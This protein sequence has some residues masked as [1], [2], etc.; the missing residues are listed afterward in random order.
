MSRGLTPEEIEKR[1][2]LLRTPIDFEDLIEAGVLRQEGSWYQIVDPERVPGHLWAHILCA[3][4][5]GEGT[6][7]FRFPGG[8]EELEG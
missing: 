2:Q 5:D 7:L 6:F 3:M 4:F 1:I 8:L